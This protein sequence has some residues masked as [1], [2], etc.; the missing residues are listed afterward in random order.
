MHKYKLLKKRKS[1]KSYKMRLQIESIIDLMKKKRI[2][3]S[4]FDE[5]AR[6]YID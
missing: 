2:F 3:L 6:R 1:G 4:T 5:N